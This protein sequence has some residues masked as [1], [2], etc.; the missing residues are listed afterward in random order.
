MLL[1]RRLLLAALVVALAT[2]A[3]DCVG[4][5]TPEQAMLFASAH[6]D[7]RAIKLILCEAL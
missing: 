6:Q 3:L 5:A 2:Y 7:G 1:A 4:M